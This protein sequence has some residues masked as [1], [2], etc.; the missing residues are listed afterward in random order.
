MTIG[1]QWR[2]HEGGVYALVACCR[3]EATGEPHVIYVLAS[4]YP[5]GEFWCRPLREWSEE[6][7]PGVKR[8]TRL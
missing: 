5:D 3:L 1:S 2:H 6:V 8:F 4:T 7:A